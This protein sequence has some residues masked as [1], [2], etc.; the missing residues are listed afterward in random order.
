M[1]HINFTIMTV[2]II[3][4]ASS[5]GASVL[6]D[7]AM[8]T[9][10][11]AQDWLYATDPVI[12]AS[13]TQSAGGGV[14]TLDTTP[15][16][17]DHAGYFAGTTHPGLTALDRTGDGF[18]L[19]FT[20]ALL[21]ELHVSNDRA[22]LSILVLTSDL[23]AIELGFWADSVWAQSTAFT[24]AE[25]TAPGFTTAAATEYD[26]AV[27]GDNYNLYADDVLILSG[28]LR[29]YYLTAAHPIYGLPNLLFLGD[30]TTSAKGEF[31]LARVE[32]LDEAIP[33]PAT[34]SL[35][36]LGAMAVLKRRRA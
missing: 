30:D 12:G 32:F 26:L 34:M 16:V 3:A 5:A 8:N 25:A 7:G 36:A 20:L 17:L 21:S 33:E 11:A 22:G 28:P 9:L 13:A 15:D 19:S 14:T 6:Y 4:L 31:E 35:L 23:Q 1:R 24:R 2:A 10:P 29:S 27:L 18:T